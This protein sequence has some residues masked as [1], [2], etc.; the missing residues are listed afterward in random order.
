MIFIRDDIP[1]R[2]LTEHIFP[3]GIEGLFIELNS[4][5]TKWLLFGNITEQL[6]VTHINSII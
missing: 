2:R 5:K 1:G 3:D 6:K 4:A